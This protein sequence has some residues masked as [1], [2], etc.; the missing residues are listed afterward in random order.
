MAAVDAGQAVRRVAA[1]QGRPCRLRPKSYSR[2]A[3]AGGLRPG[4]RVTY[5]QP[6]TDQGCSPR[7]PRRRRKTKDTQHG[8]QEIHQT[9]DPGQR[10]QAQEGRQG[11][12]GL[13]ARAKGQ[14][15]DGEPG[16]VLRRALSRTRGR[17]KPGGIGTEPEPPGVSSGTRSTR[18]QQRGKSPGDSV[19]RPILRAQGSQSLARPE[20]NS[21]LRRAGRI[22]SSWLAW[23]VGAGCW[24]LLHRVPIGTPPQAPPDALGGGARGQ[25][26]SSGISAA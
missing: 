18:T 11:R 25:C 2:R 24:V 4:R 10:P 7:A 5:Q 23:T 17:L 22:S 1:E 13:H 26:V 20:K 9:H 21:G 8:D 15:V 19:S 6:A 3:F 14:Q 16:P 12:R